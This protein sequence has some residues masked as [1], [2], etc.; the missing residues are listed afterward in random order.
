MRDKAGLLI[1]IFIIAL[2]EAFMF[3]YQTEASLGLHALNIF[4]C[5]LLP[6]WSEKRM[7]LF[8]SFALISLLRVLNIGM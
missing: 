4:L 8:Q 2:A 7:L 6:V 3:S 5:I 1:P